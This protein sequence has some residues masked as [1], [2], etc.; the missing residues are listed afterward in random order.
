[1]VLRA[2]WPDSGPHCPLRVSDMG[3][4]PVH[5]PKRPSARTSDQSLPMLRGLSNIWDSVVGSHHNRL[6]SV[7]RTGLAQ[8]V[9]QNI[10]EYYWIT[11]HGK[12]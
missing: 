4:A 8:V 1:M 9:I 10:T 7:Q 2:R 12:L 3:C 5:S 6:V 11:I